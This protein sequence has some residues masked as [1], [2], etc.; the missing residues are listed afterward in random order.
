LV[1]LIVWIWRIRIMEKLSKRGNEEKN[2]QN[3]R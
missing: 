1:I 3:C 2:L